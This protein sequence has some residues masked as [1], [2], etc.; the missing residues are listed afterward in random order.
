MEIKRN[1]VEIRLTDAELEVFENIAQN[2]RVS[3][4][5]DVVFRLKHIHIDEWYDTSTDETIADVFDMRYAIFLKDALEVEYNKQR[6]EGIL[7]YIIIYKVINYYEKELTDEE[8]NSYQ[9]RLF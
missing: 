8:I 7:D 6:Q 1:Q 4:A 9:D 3:Q 2:F 5:K